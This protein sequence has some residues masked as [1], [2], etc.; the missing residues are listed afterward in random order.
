[1]ASRFSSV[2]VDE[3]IRTLSTEMAIDKDAA[4]IGKYVACALE[5]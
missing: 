4:F 2:P 5:R 1:M 3:A